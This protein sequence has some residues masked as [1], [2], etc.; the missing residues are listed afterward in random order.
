LAILREEEIDL[1]GGGGLW[2]SMNGQREKNKKKEGGKKFLHVGPLLVNHSSK[3]LV[4]LSA[5]KLLT[6]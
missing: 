4:K 3:H 2:D 6:Y 1:D 5:Q